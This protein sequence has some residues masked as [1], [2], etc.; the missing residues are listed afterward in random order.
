MNEIVKKNAL[1]YGLI[2]GVVAVLTTTY[3]YLNPELFGSMALGFSIIGFYIILGIYLMIKTKKELGGNYSFKDA[4]TTYFVY[5]VV[6]ILISTVFT[7]ILY[8]FIDPSAKE[9]VK[10][11]TIKSTVGTME[12][13][14]T[15]KAAME[16][17][18]KK[19]E[20]QDQFSFGTQFQGSLISI[21]ISAIFGLI[22]GAIF[23]SK[24][25]NQL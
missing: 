19:L 17:A 24:S 16:E 18:I 2:S 8:N 10:E 3:L 11:V 21:L 13:F 7:V 23:K 1:Q 15:P 9:I 22:L 6:G 14:G 25:S 20:E 4:F 5:A 12:K